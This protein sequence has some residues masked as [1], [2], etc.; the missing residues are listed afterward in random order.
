MK[1]LRWIH[2]LLAGTVV[3]VLICAAWAQVASYAITNAKI[4]TISGGVIDNG[5]IVIRDGKIAAVGKSVGVPGG[6]RVINARGLEVYPGLIDAG[7]QLGL[8][9]IGSV[10]ATVDTTEI[11]EYNPQIMAAAAIHPASEHIPVTRVNGISS[12]LTRPA[13]STIAGQA[14]L[15]HLA[16]WTINEMAIKKSVGM[17]LN[18][19]SLSPGRRFDSS[20]FTQ[21][22]AGFAEAR[23]NYERR[24]E[25]LRNLF[26]EA[27]AYLQAKEAAAK[28]TALPK[29]DIDLKLEALIPVI[30]GEMPLLVEA[31]RERDI[32]SAVEFAEKEKLR[33]ILTGG[34]EAWR[35]AELLKEKKLPVILGK[36]IS[37]PV[38]E[39]DAYDSRFA[40]P[41]ALFKAGVKFCFSSEDSSNAR[42]LPYN[43]GTAVAFG[44]PREEAL[45]AL[46]L[47]TAQILGVDSLI[48]SI[49]VGKIADLVVTDGDIFELKT[50]I[51]HLFIGGKPIDLKTKHT[52]LAEKYMARP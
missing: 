43:A 34:E 50:Q 7:S 38:R 16:G 28:N 37:M 17:V 31:N 22:Q 52:D 23:R 35:V 24:I 36:V 29:I 42:N 47:N 11:G 51:R 32:K 39:D 1:Q 26:K 48:G 46:T 20:S 15:M 9:E 4:Y 5:T 30:K 49:E 21:R 27:R 25:E 44:L 33:I 2:W 14:V 10:P 41:A 3:L 8:T 45:K 13:G 18:F 6:A 12:A 40:A 19:P